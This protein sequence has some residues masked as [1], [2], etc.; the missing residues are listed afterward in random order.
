MGWSMTDGAVIISTSVQGG[1]RC[2][3]LCSLLGPDRTLEHPS[4]CLFFSLLIPFPTHT[5][6]SPQALISGVEVYSCSEF[7]VPRSSEE[8]H[9]TKKQPKLE[10]KHTAKKQVVQA[11]IVA[12]DKIYHTINNTFLSEVC[13]LTF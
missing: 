6:S 11:E 12:D 5:A 7:S 9:K 13:E 8:K 1:W 10:K 2:S 4:A 3:G